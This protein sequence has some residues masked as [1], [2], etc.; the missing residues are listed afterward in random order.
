MM[1]DRDDNQVIV[2]LSVEQAV[3]KAPDLHPSRTKYVWSSKTRMGRD[4][5]D[6]V[7]DGGGELFTQPG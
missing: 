4:Q 1:R 3:G 5:T 6:R 2:T 7:L